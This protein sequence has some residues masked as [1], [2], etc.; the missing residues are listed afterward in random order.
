MHVGLLIRRGGKKVPGLPGAC[1]TR[2]FTYLV[3]D[4]WVGFLT[5]SYLTMVIDRMAF[6]TCCSS[7][8]M[9]IHWIACTA[10]RHGLDNLLSLSPLP[11]FGYPLPFHDYQLH[12]LLYRYRLDG[13]H[14]L[15]LLSVCGYRSSGGPTPYCSLLSLVINW[16]AFTDCCCGFSLGVE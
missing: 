8:Y 7:L 1:A 2:N 16:V 4:P 15:P 9:A 11:L 14:S 12:S 5:S 6:T 10:C 3:R 13:L